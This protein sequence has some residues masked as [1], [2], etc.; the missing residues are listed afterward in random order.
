M[1][2]HLR[3]ILCDRDL[4]RALSQAGRATIL[5]RHTCTHRVNELLAI[6]ATLGATEGGVAAVKGLEM[7]G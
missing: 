3:T 4:A 6:V 5:A 2:Q 1:E 7:V